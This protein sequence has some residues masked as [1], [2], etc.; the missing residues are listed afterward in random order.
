MWHFIERHCA[1]L[2]RC[3]SGLDRQEWIVVFAGALIIGYFCMKGF[4]SRTDY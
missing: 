3:L 2:F 4:G 1:P